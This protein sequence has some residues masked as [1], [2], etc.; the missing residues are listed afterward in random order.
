MPNTYSTAL[1]SAVDTKTNAFIAEVEQVS[2]ENSGRLFDQ[3]IRSSDIINI[4]LY[5]ANGVQ[6]SPPTGTSFDS[7]QPTAIASSGDDDIPILSNSYYFSFAD[8]S[9]RYMLVVYTGA[10]QVA[11]LQKA[12]KGIFPFLLAVILV[13]SLASSWVYSRIITKPVL[14]ISNVSEKMSNLQLEWQLKEERTDEL[15][16]LEKSLST[17][18]R[19]LSATISELKTTNA[20][21]EKEIEFEKALEQARLDFFS[22]ASHE[23][24]T[25]IT[26]IKGQ[27]EG[28]LLG[29]GAYKER[30]KYLARS[31][32][33]ANALEKMVQ[34][35]LVISRLENSN[36]NLKSEQ[37][38]A[39]LI[40][41]EYLYATED[42][43]AEKDLQLE[44]NLPQKI[45]CIGNKIL[46]EKVFSNLISNAIIYSPQEA[47]V[48]IAAV[49]QGEQWLFFIEN[50]G[51]YIPENAIPQLFEAFYRIEQSRS[52]KTGGSGLGL[53]IVQKILEQHGS[54]CSVCNTQTGVR[55]YF[56]I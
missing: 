46:M 9:D 45:C 39:A 33:V 51:S 42:L 31:L 10:A 2:F 32:E 17:L 15:G 43:I 49:K 14:K 47:T 25:P 56:T 50:T 41:Q 21:L 44:V 37:F 1:S 23:L 24:K 38:D 52:R 22:A 4:S 40:V 11:E 18:S 8:N 55:F 34:E 12:F 27:L 30:E 7:M 54:C 19:K 36:V 5:E 16:V 3:F 6:I 48:S 35:I 26:I 20:K 13:V 53:Y 29:V 28:M